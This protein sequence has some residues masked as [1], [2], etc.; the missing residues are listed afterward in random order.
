MCS[1]RSSRTCS[2]WL[3][4]IGAKS[5]DEHRYDQ[6]HAAPSLVSRKSAFR[7]SAD[8]RQRARPH[9]RRGLRSISRSTLH[10][11]I[12][13]KENLITEAAE[14]PLQQN[15]Q[16]TWDWQDRLVTVAH[17]E[18]FVAAGCRLP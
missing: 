9:A 11:D 12:S 8:T 16:P 17:C 1:S 2:C 7:E 13:P 6:S 4:S 5:A 10:C 14:E 3:M 18:H 15:D